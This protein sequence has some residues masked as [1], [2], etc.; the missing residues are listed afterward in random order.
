MTDAAIYVRI[1]AD[2]EALALGVE[3]QEQDCRAK[4]AELGLDVVQVFSDNNI[5]ASRKGR[6]P[7]PGYSALIEA[8]RAG[9]FTTVIA[10]SSSRLTRRPRELEDLIDLSEH[11]QVRFVY[12]K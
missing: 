1:S 6:K 2:Q 8:A 4:A 10:Y 9:K 7:R 12:C 3:R 5:S 11:R